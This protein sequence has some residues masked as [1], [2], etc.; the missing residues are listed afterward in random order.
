[1]EI[2]YILSLQMKDDFTEAY[3]TYESIMADGHP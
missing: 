3:S 1:M 2:V